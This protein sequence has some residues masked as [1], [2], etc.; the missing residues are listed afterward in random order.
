MYFDI[1]HLTVKS[2]KAFTE[3][4]FCKNKIKRG[5][6]TSCTTRTLFLKEHRKFEAVSLNRMTRR[7]RTADISEDVE[8]QLCEILNKCV[9]CSLTLDESS[10]E[11]CIFSRAVTLCLKCLKDM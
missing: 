3:G 2:S 6:F 8:T 11:M 4:D 10:A 1:W 5:L 9:Y 7:K